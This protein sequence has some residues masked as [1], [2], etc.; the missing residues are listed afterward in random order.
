[1]NLLEKLVPHLIFAAALLP[2][3]LIAAAAAVSLLATDPSFALR[4]PV[5]TAAACPPPESAAPHP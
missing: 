2:T 4:A 5:Q 3:A 1:M